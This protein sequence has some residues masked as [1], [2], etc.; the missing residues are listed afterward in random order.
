MGD[1]FEGI[2]DA[3]YFWMHLALSDLRSRWRRSFF[4]ILWSILQPLGTALLLAAVLARLFGMN[5]RSY[6]PFIISGMIV[7]D[8]VI[9]VSTGGSLSFV[10]ADAYIKQTAHPLAI[11]S[12]RTALANMVVLMLASLPMFVWAAIVRPDLLGVRWIAALSI[13]PVLLLVFWP[14]ITLLSYL[15]SRFRDLPNV[16]MLILQAVWFV[17]PVYFETAMFRKAGLNALVDYNPVFHLLQLIRAPLLDGR[18]PSVVD[19][20][21]CGGMALL[22]TALAWLVGRKA[23]KNTIFYL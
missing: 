2:W 10:Q 6:A 22:F 12:L 9:S 4:G 21:F 16:M 1:Y 7:W 15:G 18:W 3:R 11:Y 13:Y 5:L 8:F 17:S 23:E 20:G 14:L 19:Y